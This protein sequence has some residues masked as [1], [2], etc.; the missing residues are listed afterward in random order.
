M[1]PLFYSLIQTKQDLWIYDLKSYKPHLFYKCPHY[2]YQPP[3]TSF[4]LNSIN[5]LFLRT[6]Y[7]LWGLSWAVQNLRR[8]I[9]Q[10]FC[11][12]KPLRCI[13]LV[14]EILAVVILCVWPPLNT[15][16]GIVMKGFFH[17]VQGRY[18]CKSLAQRTQL[19]YS[20]YQ[21]YFTS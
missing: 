12:F 21:Y 16:Y 8:W 19:L 17:A 4:I 2:S 13:I 7:Y 20:F 18:Q 11:Q 1:H 14:L 9:V 5:Y 10:G 15:I 3:V 6:F